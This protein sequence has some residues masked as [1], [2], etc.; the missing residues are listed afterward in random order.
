MKDVNSVMLAITATQ[1]KNFIES[2]WFNKKATGKDFNTNYKLAFL[3]L[4]NAVEKFLAVLNNSQDDL[5]QY[6]N[7]LSIITLM[8]T[9]AEPNDRTKILESLEF[10]ARNSHIIDNDKADLIERVKMVSEISDKVF[11]FEP[12]ELAK[13]HKKIVNTPKKKKNE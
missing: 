8:L 2:I 12:L 6:A 11:E 4:Q 7:S 5:M 10:L 9:E 13:I 1:M 3:N